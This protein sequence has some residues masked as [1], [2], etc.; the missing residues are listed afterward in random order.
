MMSMSISLVWWFEIMEDLGGGLI[1][2]FCCINCML[3]ILRSPNVCSFDHC[4]MHDID[5]YLHAQVYISKNEI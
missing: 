1:M 2:R 5:V 3:Y 4:H